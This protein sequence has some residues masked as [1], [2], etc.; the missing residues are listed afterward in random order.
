M[1]EHR[2]DY[3]KVWKANIDGNDIVVGWAKPQP[4][5]NKAK[6]S[7]IHPIHSEIRLI[8]W[9]QD[10][11][12]PG[13]KVHL[14]TQNSPC[15]DCAHLN[16]RSIVK[17]KKDNEG[18]QLHLHHDEMYVQKG[19]SKTEGAE[20][21]RSSK[22]KLLELDTDFTWTMRINSEKIDPVKKEDEDCK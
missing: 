17:F 6:N 13:M 7:L 15:E 3:V 2:D 8:E 14:W 21:F 11:T 20:E 4:I 16:A 5:T 22:Q 19:K 10:E 18:M 12:T 9:L 1:R